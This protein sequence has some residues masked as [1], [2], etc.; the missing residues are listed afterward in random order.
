MQYRAR[1]GMS[2]VEI[3]IAMVVLSLLMAIAAPRLRQGRADADIAVT[4]VAMAI[5]Q[6]QRIA[7]TRQTAV[8]V[9]IDSAGRRVRVAE[10]VNGNA[11]IDPGERTRWYPLE[12]RAT[13]VA[14]PARVTGERV[15]GAISGAGL[16]TIGG[17][18]SLTLRRDGSA[19]VALEAYLSGPGTPP[20]RRALLVPKATARAEW[21]RWDGTAWKRGAL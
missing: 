16:D 6:A 19:S 13:F 18:P 21:Y 8:L 20:D 17:L 4:Q 15:E 1:V 9:S 3:V 5:E 7:L 11:G 2:L 10:D 14:P 12:G